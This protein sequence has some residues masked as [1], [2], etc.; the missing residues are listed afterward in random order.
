MENDFLKIQPKS[1]R[2]PLPKK[3]II[4]DDW[5]KE[6]HPD[7]IKY[8]ERVLFF[9]PTEIYS[10]IKIDPFKRIHSISIILFFPDIP[11]KCSCGC[12]LDLPRRHSRFSTENCSCFAWC[13]RNIIC[14]AHQMP[15]KFITKYSGDNCDECK[16]NPGTELDH[17]I[18][19]KHGGGGCW[20]S[21]YR[22]LCAKCHRY[23]TN[24]D[25]GFKT[26][27]QNNERN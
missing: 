27:K 25:F 4:Y 12:G 17:I 23:K 5:V 16:N 21:N 6:K 7:Y 20:L 24:T 1:C 18:G 19:V 11:G 2:V 15:R 26:L 3:E 22:W 14:N 9:D 10:R 13:V 8:W